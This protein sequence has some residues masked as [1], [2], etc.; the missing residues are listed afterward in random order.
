M[1]FKDIFEAKIKQEGDYHRGMSI[2]MHVLADFINRGDLD[3]DVTDIDLSGG[4]FIIY[5][6]DEMDSI[7]YFFDIDISE[8]SYYKSGTYEDPPESGACEYDFIN[9]RIEI[10]H[11]TG[12][13]IETVYY[14][15]DFTN[16]KKLS[17]SH[18]VKMDGEKLMYKTFDEQI[19]EMDADREPDYPEPDYD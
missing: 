3:L 16:F 17:L 8:H 10:S 2:A 13:E 19:Q 6:E 14:G 18:D 7:E 1:K 5:S 15:P 9:M 12:N 4:S 11:A